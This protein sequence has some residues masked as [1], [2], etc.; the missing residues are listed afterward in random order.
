MAA[1]MKDVRERAEARFRKAEQAAIAG[2]KARAEY[3]AQQNAIRKRTDRL[4][5]ERL[6]REEKELSSPPPEAGAKRAK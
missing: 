3:D 5:A 4:R 1:A 2:N 6:A